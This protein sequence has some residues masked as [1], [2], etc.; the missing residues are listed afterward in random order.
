MKKKKE[1]KFMSTVA[2]DIILTKFKDGMTLLQVQKLFYKIMRRHGIKEG[3]KSGNGRI[4]SN[5]EWTMC[6]ELFIQTLDGYL[7]MEFFGFKTPRDLE[8]Y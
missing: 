7:K 5:F 1:I 2:K 8:Q 4:V 6:K 3:T